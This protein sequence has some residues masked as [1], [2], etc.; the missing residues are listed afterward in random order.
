MGKRDK[1]LIRR[2]LQSLV[3]VAVGLLAGAGCNSGGDNGRAITAVQDPI[4]RDI[5]RPAGFTLVDKDSMARSSGRF[6]IARC[7][8]T[9]GE[10]RAAVQRFYEQYMPSAGFEIRHSSFDKGTLDLQFESS[11]EIC[12][13]RIYPVGLRTR[14]VV[15]VGPKA[16]GSAERQPPPLRSIGNP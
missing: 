6:R 3:C 4:I 15:E 13:V 10:D 8:Y 14:I 12:N 2:Y 1:C 16:Q 5:P 11:S 7:E 9:G